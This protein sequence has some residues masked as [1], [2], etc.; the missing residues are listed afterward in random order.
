MKNETVTLA[1]TWAI[2]AVKAKGLRRHKVH[3]SAAGRCLYSTVKPRLPQK[4]VRRKMTKPVT[5]GFF[6]RM[7]I[8]KAKVI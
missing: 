5:K 8:K 4:T 7:L 1:L 6:T 3:S 2:P